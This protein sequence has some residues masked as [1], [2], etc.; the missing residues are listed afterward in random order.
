MLA[1][2][3][4]VGSL[5]NIVLN[6]VLIPRFGM[7]G[8]AAATVG[9]IIIWKS[10]LLFSARREIGLDPSVLGRAAIKQ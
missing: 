1:R 3:L 2:A 10:I 6:A 8:A 9:G 4:A 5:S 7:E